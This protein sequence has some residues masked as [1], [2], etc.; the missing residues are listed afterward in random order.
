[1]AV[2]YDVILG[3]LREEDGAP[4]G[5]GG[6]IQF[7]NG[8]SLGAVTL[9]YDESQAPDTYLVGTPVDPDVNGAD[10]SI[11]GGQGGDISGA[12]ITANLEVLGHDYLANEILTVV[13]GDNNATVQVN[14]V[15]IGELYTIQIAN[16]GSGYTVLDV[17]T[18]SGGNGD[19][20]FRVEAVGGSG[21]VSSITQ[22][23]QGT[24]YTGGSGVA[25]TGGTG[26][27]C[28]MDTYGYAIGAIVS[29]TLVDGG[30]GY[31]AGSNSYSLSGGSG[32][33]GG[34][35]GITLVGTTGGDLVIKAGVGQGAAANGR[36]KFE[37]ATQHTYYRVSTLGED[38]Q[39][40]SGAN[41]TE[42]IE[43]N[44]PRN[45]SSFSGV[46]TVVSAYGSGSIGKIMGEKVGLF[47]SATHSGNVNVGQSFQ[48]YATSNSANNALKGQEM[49]LYVAH[50]SGNMPSLYGI[51]LSLL[52]NGSGNITNGSLFIGN[53]TNTGYISDVALVNPSLT[54]SGTI[55]VTKGYYLGDIT[56]GTQ[57]LKPYN[58][59]LTDD[60]ARNVMNGKTGLGVDDP[61]ATL[62][63][64]AGTAAAGTAPIKLTSGTSLTTPEAG[65]I[66]F[67]GTNFYLTV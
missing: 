53:I 56:S 11:S 52:M 2:K 37:G 8:G 64:Q 26:T 38:G 61:T 29:L 47:S 34:I 59:W 22:L 48:V 24:G 49:E 3:K 1:M 10:V 50:N 6:Q 62:H 43:V 65:T 23:T 9:S 14:S 17:L 12:I 5:E 55:G 51:D 27:G 18:V 7:N 42:T 32:T 15:G 4:A 28:T 57:T 30:T 66:E 63:L 36:V 60:Q 16:L 45:I 58:I 46:E 21:E 25:T 44:S 35:Q 54:N 40:I 31:L 19:C 13:G 41:S 20:T 67:D 33:D 39:N